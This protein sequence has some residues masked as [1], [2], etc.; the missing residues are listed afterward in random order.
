MQVLWNSTPESMSQ[1]LWTKDKHF[2]AV[3]LKAASMRQAHIFPVV[4]VSPISSLQFSDGSSGIVEQENPNP[5]LQ[6]WSCVAV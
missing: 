3:V 4:Q 5:F 2:L 6:W 1:V